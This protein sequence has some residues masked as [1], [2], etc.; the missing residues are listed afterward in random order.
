MRISPT[1]PARLIRRMRLPGLAVAAGLVLLASGARAAAPTFGP[2]E[3]ARTL[4]A[5]SLAEQIR[6]D[7]AAKTAQVLA[8]DREWPRVR[9]AVAAGWQNWIALMPALMPAADAATARSL[10]GALRQALLLNTAAVLAALD[11]KNGPV[12]GGQAVCAPGGMPA[13]WRGRAIRA[14][15]ALHDIHLTNQGGDCLRALQG[16]S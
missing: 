4:T 14:V 8:Q 7:G 11:P 2:I 6:Q 16:V 1:L 10:Q 13:A 3:A 9:R 15:Q 12:R 5:R